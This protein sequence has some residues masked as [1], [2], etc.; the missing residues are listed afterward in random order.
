MDLYMMKEMFSEEKYQE[1]KNYCDELLESSPQDNYIYKITAYKYKSMALYKMGCYG[2]AV[3]NYHNAS[4]EYY[5]GYKVDIF[6][7]PT[8]SDLVFYTGASFYELNIASEAVNFYEK[9]VEVNPK[10][11]YI[12]KTLGCL[13]REFGEYMKAL[14]YFSLGFDVSEEA[15]HHNSEGWKLIEIG[16]QNPKKEPI[17]A[18][19]NDNDGGYEAENLEILR[20]PSTPSAY[21]LADAVINHDEGVEVIA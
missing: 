20:T 19:T 1:L 21:I 13:F 11:S 18:L 2:E 14:T 4:K 7:D 16:S 3:L 8:H 17:F 12:Y 5:L 9:A 15:A 10:A 6:N